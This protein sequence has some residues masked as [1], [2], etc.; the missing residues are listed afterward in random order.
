MSIQSPTKKI[1][2][3]KYPCL[4]VVAGLTMP[5]LAD[6]ERGHRFVKSFVVRTKSRNQSVCSM[7]P[8]HSLYGGPPTV[9]VPVVITWARSEGSSVGGVLLNLHGPSHEP[10]E[11]LQNIYVSMAF[12][13]SRKYKGQQGGSTASTIKAS[14][15]YVIKTT[16]HEGARGLI[17]EPGDF[18]VITTDTTMDR[19]PYQCP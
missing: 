9:K 7:S 16:N 12:T 13:Q 8:Y 1:K 6:C 4:K 14:P 19:G 15:R 3:Q 17:P 18:F 10:C 2:G 5:I 11:G